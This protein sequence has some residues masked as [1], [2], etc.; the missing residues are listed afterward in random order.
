MSLEDPTDSASWA[1]QR[2]ADKLAR[3]RISEHADAA[4]RARLS[5]HPEEAV[6]FLKAAL[7][8]FVE[9][10]TVWPLSV[11][12]LLGGEYGRVAAALNDREALE[13]IAAAAERVGVARAAMSSKETD[14]RALAAS[15]FD[16]LH[17]M[18]SIRSILEVVGPVSVDEMERRARDNEVGPVR[19][20]VHWMC[21]AGVAH[22][23][24]D[25]VHLG[26][27]P[28]ELRPVRPKRSVPSAAVWA[29]RT[30]EGRKAQLE[31][32]A[33]FKAGVLRGSP[34]PIEGQLEYV[35]RLVEDLSSG[36]V[37][38]FQR[39]LFLLED[40][41]PATYL[42]RLLARTHAETHLLGGDYELAFSI[43]QHRGVPLDLYINLYPLVEERALTIRTINTWVGR[44]QP[45][46][47]AFG[48]ENREDV[49]QALLGILDSYRQEHGV[50]VAW[51]IWQ[52]F[53]P[54][55]SGEGIV[56]LLA[57][58]DGFIDAVTLEQFGRDSEGSRECRSRGD[59]FQSF[60]AIRKPV[61]WPTPFQSVDGFRELMELRLGQL[62]RDAENSVRIA[63]GLPRVNE[64]NLAESL[65]LRELRDAFPG[66]RI[67]HQAR[68]Q[69]LRP[70]SID[71]FFADENVGVEYQGAQH[72]TPIEYFGGRA[73]F[74]NQ[75][76]RDAKK[77]ERCEANACRLI[78]V[79][80]GYHLPTVIAEISAAL[81]EPARATEG[82]A[83]DGQLF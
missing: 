77:R 7:R 39:A 30:D 61:P 15:Y 14:A 3:A 12:G 47:T 67:L 59:A 80:P 41:Y 20:R 58:D 6:S 51:D 43:L 28:P 52:R 38:E 16:D 63:S 8:E 82:S 78:E 81:R 62:Y 54:H 1:Q 40:E 17:V 68:P 49:E 31:F 26:P 73:A 19:Q 46:L 72:S 60:K 32:Y 35:S 70:Q 50:N 29:T 75:R 57:R 83:L 2:E 53:V 74:H 66:S 48:A 34:P 13:L 23:I 5:N 69:W 42:P 36:P 79:H 9:H 4:L 22:L 71:I 25:E 21:K 18:N 56:G 37:D 55:R 24:G 44:K 45:R 33:S 27:L 11:R 76:A 65:L 10:T 64:G